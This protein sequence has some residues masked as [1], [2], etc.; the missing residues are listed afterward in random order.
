MSP[1]GT[2]IG[3][4]KPVHWLITTPVGKPVPAVAAGTTTDRS[5]V[6]CDAQSLASSYSISRPVPFVATHADRPCCET[7]DDEERPHGAQL[8][9]G[10]QRGAEDMPH[11]SDDD[12]ET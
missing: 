2:V 10:G 4:G 7:D 9:A 8:G 5:R 6:A 12:D 3:I 11:E 1:V